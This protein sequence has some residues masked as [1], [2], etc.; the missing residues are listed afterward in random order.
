MATYITQ[1]WRKDCVTKLIG[2]VTY[3]ERAPSSLVTA[4][5][6]CRE[7]MVLFCLVQELDSCQNNLFWKHA[8]FNLPSPLF[9]WIWRGVVGKFDGWRHGHL[10]VCFRKKRNNAY[11]KKHSNSLLPSSLSIAPAAILLWVCWH[12]N[13]EDI[14]YIFPSHHSGR[15]TLVRISNF[16]NGIALGDSVIV[17]NTLLVECLSRSSNTSKFIHCFC[18]WMKEKDPH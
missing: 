17:Q 3:S 18:R 16:G 15:L 12:L 8:C 10:T 7:N 13:W 4:T 5:N 2:V 9:Q 11:Y 6:V 1:S 14:L